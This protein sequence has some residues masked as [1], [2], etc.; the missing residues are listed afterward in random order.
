M[1]VL[2]KRIAKYELTLH[3]EKTRLVQFG[4]EALASADRAGTKPDT[5]DFLGFSHR[6]ARSRRWVWHH[7]ATLFMDRLRRFVLP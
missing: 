6:C 7:L 4:R 1:N 3:P 2:P 5:F